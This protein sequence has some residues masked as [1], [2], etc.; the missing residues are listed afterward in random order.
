LTYTVYQSNVGMNTANSA[1]FVF[2]WLLLHVLCSTLEG[3]LYKSMHIDIVFIWE[4]F[5]LVFLYR[6]VY[7]S[8]AW[9][10]RFWNVEPSLGLAVHLLFP[11]YLFISVVGSA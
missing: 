11:R 4:S 9:H 2:C 6:G 7:R 8:D 1:T 10:D 3:S 5:P